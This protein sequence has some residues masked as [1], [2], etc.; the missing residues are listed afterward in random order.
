MLAQYLIFAASALVF[1]MG[2]VHLLLTLFTNTFEPRDAALFEQ[3]RSVPLKFSKRLL[4]APAL[5]GFNGSHSLGPM[6]FGVIY[7]YLALEHGEFLFASP[8]LLAVGA[9]ALAAYA[10]LAMRYW[11][12]APLTGISIAL[13]L[14]IA[15]IVLH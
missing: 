4:T 11:F 8:F 13:V 2:T 7:G 1:A 10:L 14:F 15:G 9:C 6:L 5:K 12:W 3:I